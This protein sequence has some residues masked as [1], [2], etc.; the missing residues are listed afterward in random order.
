MSPQDAQDPRGG[1]DAEEL[2]A[3]CRRLADAGL[4]PGSS[5]NVSVRSGDWILATPTGRELAG[6]GPGDL[7]VLDG[8]GRHRAGPP[9]TKEVPL[10]LRL[11]ARE[12]GARAVVHLHS[13]HAVAAACLVPAD[14]ASALPPYTPYSVM[15]LGAVPLLPYARPGSDRLAALVD[16]LPPGTRACLL[17]KHGSLTF[18]DRLDTAAQAAAE[19]EE[20]AR[21]HLLL[22]PRAEV[23]LLT[24]EQCAELRR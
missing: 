21:L 13:P 22:S 4:S 5:G 7:S 19:L 15:R 9:P 3:A 14:T 6:L 18:A 23:R 1:A 20:S 10:H 16:D 17:A 24:P 2:A 11:Y 12:S 8:K